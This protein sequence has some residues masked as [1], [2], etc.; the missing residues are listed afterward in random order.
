MIARAAA[1]SACLLASGCGL[2]VDT[3]Y[4]SG[5]KHYTERHEERAPTAESRTAIEYDATVEPDGRLRLVCEERT[6][7]IERSWE[8]VKTFE[9]RGG[10]PK[11]VYA[12]TAM[13]DGIFGAVVAGTLLA[14]CLQ[15]DSDTSCWHTAWASPFALDLG[16][17]LYRRH[18]AKTPKLVDKDRTDDRLALARA[19]SEARPVACAESVTQVMVG[20]ASGPSEESALNGE[21]SNAEP[22]RMAEGA[23]A[24]PFDPDGALSLTSQPDAISLWLT[25]RWVGLWVVDVQGT[26]HPVSVDRCAALRPH[27]ARFSGPA[28]EQF[29]KDCPPPRLP[30]P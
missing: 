3:I 21:S 29:Q 13:M 5:D 27:V 12:G 26:A 25:Q 23:L 1:A 20:T 9:Y 10:Y 2:L 8:V 24:L 17:S 16:W 28:L 11:N 7:G 15:D 14:V 6:R 19:P 18:G 4:W 22:R 30:Q